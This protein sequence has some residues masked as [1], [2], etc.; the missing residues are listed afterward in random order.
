MGGDTK[1]VS[2]TS[3]LH[4]SPTPPSAAFLRVI[5]LPLRLTPS[6]PLTPPLPYPPTHYPF[7]HPLPLS[8]PLPPATDPPG[9]PAPAHASGP[10]GLQA[11]VCSNIQQQ[12][13]SQQ[14]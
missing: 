6:L 12:G 3:A 11:A 8:S 13:S 14:Q 10:A 2:H 7:L 1:G 9:L 4:P 5:P